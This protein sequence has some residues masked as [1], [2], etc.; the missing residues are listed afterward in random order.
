MSDMTALECLTTR[1]S[2]AKLTTPMPSE[3][4]LE[5]V[6][7][8]ALRAPDHA[9]LRPWR[10]VSV[11]GDGLNALSDLFVQYTRQQALEQGQATLTQKQIDS[12]HAKGQRAPLVI[13]VVVC[14][15]EHPKVPE[16]EQILS[17]GA[18]AQNM[19]LALHALGYQAIWRT[20]DLSRSELARHTFALASHEA[21]VALLYVGTAST[22]LKPLP[23]LDVN[24]FVSSLS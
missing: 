15:K 17:A 13:A 1:N 16:S 19:L 20:G 11:S 24:E 8:S 10:F 23:T 14:I 21:I 4:E 9:R 18:A 22:A 7:Q 3:R 12:A 6:F 5:L 2:C